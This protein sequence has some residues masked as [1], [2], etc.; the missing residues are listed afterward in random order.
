MKTNYKRVL[1]LLLSALML[2]AVAGTVLAEDEIKITF[3]QL[4]GLDP[5]PDSPV[6]LNEDDE[7]KIPY[8]KFPATEAGEKVYLDWARPNGAT[9]E[10]VYPD[11]TPFEHSYDDSQK[12]RPWP[13]SAVSRD[14]VTQITF[15]GVKQQRD[16]NWRFYLLY[17]DLDNY[18]NGSSYNTA[19]LDNKIPSIGTQGTTGNDWAYNGK[20]IKDYRDQLITNAVDFKDGMLFKPEWE[21]ELYGGNYNGSS[22]LYTVDKYVKEELMPPLEGYKWST[23]EGT[24]TEPKYDKTVYSDKKPVLYAVQ[25]FTIYFELVG[26]EDSPDFDPV[27]RAVGETYELPTSTPTKDGFTFTGWRASS[28]SG[29]INVVDNKFK[30]PV[31]DVTLTAQWEPKD[32][33]HSWSGDW[34]YNN[35][36]HWHECTAEDC[37]VTK[38]TE[39]G[40]YGVHTWK[41][42]VTKPATA[43]EDGTKTS[44]CTVCNIT[45]TERIPATGGG[46]TPST[47]ATTTVKTSATT[48]GSFTVSSKTAKAGTTVKVTPKANEGYEVGTV[49]VTDSK[50]NAVTVTKNSDGT[51]SFVVPSNTPVTVSVTF[52]KE[53][54]PA[55][56][57]PFV[58]VS[59]GDYYYDAV[60][61]AVEKG[62]TTGTGDGTTFSPGQGC[63]RAQF[64]TFLWRAA[65]RPE[66]K[67]SVN[68][69]SDVSTTKHADYYKAILWAVEQGITTGT[70]DGTTFE[71]DTIVI[72]AQSVTLMHRYAKQAGIATETGTER[73]DDVTNEGELVYYYDAIGWAV[74][75]GI[76]DGIGN[77][78]FGPRDDCI[79]GQMITFLYR[80]FTDA[81][82]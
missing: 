32:H 55:P 4:A 74:A 82:A 15:D 39:K 65:G 47:P 61:W 20:S 13:N 68:P 46:T 69:F 30:M 73:F 60:Q 57:N 63:T 52:V 33:E 48:N 25:E 36:H 79:R 76:T 5:Q 34:A 8:N 50:G 3:L 45:K 64:V 6:T 29:E 72:R 51:Y 17:D 18:Y 23:T 54:E 56:A 24:Y 43:T 27:K 22:G 44:T 26:G 38:D 16:Y 71:P 14:K 11:L 77:N 40:S 59:S 28:D 49:T 2:L 53:E 41:T 12:L 35:D 10:L 81:T 1:S 75:N 67:R 7:G 66:P 42:E 58:D 9:Y 78:N 70:G 62:V 21:I 37:P 31:G 19:A 80:L